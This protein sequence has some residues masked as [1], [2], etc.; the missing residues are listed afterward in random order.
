MITI[1]CVA[2]ICHNNINMSRHVNIHRHVEHNI[3]L[4]EPKRY[5]PYEFRLFY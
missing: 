3:V 5:I 2:S 1:I 4:H